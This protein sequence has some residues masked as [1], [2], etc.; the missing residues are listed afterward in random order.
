MQSEPPRGVCGQ[1]QLLCCAIL[2]LRCPFS[3]CTG[4]WQTFAASVSL[5]D[6]ER[7]AADSVCMRGFLIATAQRELVPVAADGDD[8]DGG[9]VSLLRGPP[10]QEILERRLRRGSSR[11]ELEE[12][13]LL[14]SLTLPFSVLLRWWAGWAETEHTRAAESQFHRCSTISRSSPAHDHGH[15]HPRR[16]HPAV[17]GPTD[18]R[19][20]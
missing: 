5:R 11:R 1:A 10:G 8:V 15:L 13:S 2:P 7:R 16:E 12:R 14:L 3:R 19:A 17:F 18:S 6:R 9:Y 20:T 4:V